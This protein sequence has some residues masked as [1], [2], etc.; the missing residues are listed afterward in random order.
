MMESSI[1][2]LLEK[3]VNVGDVNKAKGRKQSIITQKIW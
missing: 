1:L 3:M 2:H